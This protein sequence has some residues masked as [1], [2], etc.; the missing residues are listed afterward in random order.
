VERLARYRLDHFA[1]QLKVRIRIGRRYSGR[2]IRREIPPCTI[3]RFLDR[4][5]AIGFRNK[6]IEKAFSVTALLREVVRDAGTMREQLP[7]RDLVG[8]ISPFEKVYTADELRR[9]ILRHRIVERQKASLVK[10]HDHCCR[11]ELRDARDIDRRLCGHR[12]AVV[13]TCAA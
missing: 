1:Q 7:Y 4:P 12:R 9:K 2:E 10:D 11:V 13:S 6:K 5:P 3:D 8:I